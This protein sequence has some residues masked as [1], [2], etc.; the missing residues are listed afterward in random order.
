[1]PIGIEDCVQYGIQHLAKSQQ[2]E[3]E[4]AELIKANAALA[5]KVALHEQKIKELEAK[6]KVLETP[7]SEPH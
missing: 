5:A 6:I 2:L 3:R 1:M 4:K 7:P